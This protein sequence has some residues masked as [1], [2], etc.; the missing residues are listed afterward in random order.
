MIA[1]RARSS[2]PVLIAV[3][4]SALILAGLLAMGAVATV[5]RAEDLGNHLYDRYQFGVSGSVL[6]F[7]DNVRVD[8][9]DGSTGTDLSIAEDLGFTTNKFQ[10]RMSFRW[11]PGH[12][13]E[14]EAA[15]QF[16]RRSADKTLERTISVG[17]TSFAAGLQIHSVFNT[18]NAVLT[19][20]YSIMAHERTQLGAALGLGAFFLKVGVDG[21]VSASSEDQSASA[22]YAASESFVAP[23]LALG[24]YGRF[25][26]GDRWY[27]APDIRYLQFTIDRYTPRILE[28]G[29]I[30]QYYLSKKV[31]LEA[32]YGLRSLRLDI[33]PRPEGSII[34]MSFTGSIRY[35][36][37]QFRLGV[38][39]PL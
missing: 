23:T 15:Y 36:E 3:P 2:N 19:Y 12:R 35:S 11:R 21:L 8:S 14:L 30:G 26:S 18:D 20:R 31:G 4:V 29:L 9:E 38:L 5:T 28:G 22:D 24:L 10:P 1:P 32:G 13:H 16:A 6:W 33:G 17:D 7:G 27:I 25:R 39:L 34:N 37:N